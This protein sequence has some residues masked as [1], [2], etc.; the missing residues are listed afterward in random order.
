M[1]FDPQK[2]HMYKKLFTLGPTIPQ[3][4]FVKFD[5]ELHK[6]T[7]HMLLEKHAHVCILEEF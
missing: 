5:K 2:L 4:L 7:K 3:I 1:S 6:K